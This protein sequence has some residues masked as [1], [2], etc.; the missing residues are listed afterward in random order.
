MTSCSATGPWWSSKGNSAHVGPTSDAPQPRPQDQVVDAG[1]HFVMPG[2]VRR[3]HPPGVRQRAAAKR[4]SISGAT[5]SSGR[6]AGCSSRSM[7][8]RRATPRSCVPGDAGNCSIAVRDA[9]SAGLFDGPR[10]A[11]SSNVIANRHSLN[12]W[13]PSTHRHARLHDRPAGAR[14]AMRKARRVRRQAKAG[15]DIVKDRPRR[16]QHFRE[17]GT[18]IAAFT[19]DEVSAMVEGGRTGWGKRVATHAYGKGSGDAGG[20]SRGRRCLSRLLRR[21]RM[22]RGHAEI[23]ARPWRRR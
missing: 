3:A 16:H 22:R 8:W 11:A 13:F 18:H 19:Q 1:G 14:R 12:D 20:A 23:G 2:L 17:D 15:A 10:I 9:I 4:T 6:C 21:R 7:C 5:P